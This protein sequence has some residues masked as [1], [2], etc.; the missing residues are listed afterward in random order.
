MPVRHV[1]LPRPNRTGYIGIKPRGGGVKEKLILTAGRK[2]PLP[3]GRPERSASFFRSGGMVTNDW[4]EDEIQAM[5]R[6]LA[7]DR[8]CAE[9]AKRR[10]EKAKT[11]YNAAKREAEDTDALVRGLKEELRLFSNKDK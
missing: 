9:A 11:E 7:E 4:I 6:K 10:L 3:D 1:V 8:K 5:T 2:P